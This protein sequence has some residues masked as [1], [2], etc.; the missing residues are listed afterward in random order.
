MSDLFSPRGPPAGGAAPAPAV[1]ATWPDGAGAMPSREGLGW[2]GLAPAK[3]FRLGGDLSMLGGSACLPPACPCASAAAGAAPV[4][5]DLIITEFSAA[6]AASAS[7]AIPTSCGCGSAQ[8]RLLTP[9]GCCFVCAGSEGAHPCGTHAPG[10]QAST[11]NPQC[12]GGCCEAL[13]RQL[14]LE[15]RACR[16]V[17]CQHPH[18]RQACAA[19]PT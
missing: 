12:I 16:T 7:S 17:P 5:E 15:D 10:S 8:G 1:L 18:S 2:L 11:L 4:M 13:P 6:K 14:Q 9:R 3:D 19:T